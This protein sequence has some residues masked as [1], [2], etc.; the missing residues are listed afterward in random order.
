MS[1]LVCLFVCLFVC[2]CV[3]GHWNYP[4]PSGATCGQVDISLTT[5]G[6]QS[7]HRNG[8]AGGPRS[9]L[10]RGKLELEIQTYMC[11]ERLVTLPNQNKTMYAFPPDQ[12]IHRFLTVLICLANPSLTTPNP[13]LPFP[14]FPLPNPALKLDPGYSWGWIPG[15]A[16]VWLGFG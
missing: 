1:L 16:G 2:L 7:S 12:A 3:W 13:A 14:C 4:D 8:Q 15:T 10:R 6:K 9:L 11:M 5:Q